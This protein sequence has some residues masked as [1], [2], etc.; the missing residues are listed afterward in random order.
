MWRFCCCNLSV[1]LQYLKIQETGQN[2]VY[3]LRNELMAHVEKPST[4]FFDSQRRGDIVMRITNDTEVVNDLYAN[5]I[6]CCSYVVKSSD[7]PL[8]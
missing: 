2:I 8:L 1:R 3:T 5:T 7:W 6:V 4:R